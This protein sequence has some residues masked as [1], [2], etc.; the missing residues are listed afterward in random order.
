MVAFIEGFHCSVIVL[1]GKNGMGE[2]VEGSIMGCEIS[3]LY[4]IHRVFRT[5]NVSVIE[6]NVNY[7]R[8]IN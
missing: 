3:M 6:T 5:V 2:V 4:A 1:R 7:T 8:N